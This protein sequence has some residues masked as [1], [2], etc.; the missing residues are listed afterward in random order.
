MLPGGDARGRFAR[1]DAVVPED[2]LEGK[3]ALQKSRR[4]VDG[5]HRRLD[6]GRARAAHRG[7]E[8]RFFV[9]AER[10]DAGGGQRF[11][12]G[13]GAGDLAVAAFGER[14]SRSVEIDDD[15]VAL[16]VDEDGRA[17]VGA[18]GVGAALALVAHAVGNGVFGVERGEPRV[19]HRLVVDDRGDAKIAVGVEVVLPVD[20]VD[21]FVEVADVAAVGPQER[22]Q[23]AMGGAELQIEAHHVADVAAHHHR[24]FGNFDRLVAELLHLRGRE[25]GKPLGAAEDDGVVFVG[26]EFHYF[27]LSG[28]S[29]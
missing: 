26:K 25:P 4:A 6:G 15:L 3:V 13:G 9:P 23:Y 28:I 1:D 14:L 21:E 16:P 29:T 12:H 27:C 22:H 11:L 24:V 2:R 19:A 17:D 7:D 18:A 8:R 20:G 10:H 5:H